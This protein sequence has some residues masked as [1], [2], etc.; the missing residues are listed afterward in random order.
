MNLFPIKIHL[1]QNPHPEICWVFFTVVC[2]ICQALGRTYNFL[3][4]V[5]IQ[6][7]RVVLHT[8]LLCVNVFY[9]Y[10]KI[11]RTSKLKWNT[12]ISDQKKNFWSN[13]W[14]SNHEK[15]V[16]IS[17]Y[18]T[19]KEK[20][21]KQNEKDPKPERAFHLVAPSIKIPFKYFAINY[22]CASFHIIHS[23]PILLLLWSEMSQDSAY[24]IHLK[25]SR[26]D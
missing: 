6:L 16:S 18:W 22:G 23:S 10:V 14:F 9:V 3:T 2:H 17:N 5:K 15:G 12:L 13:V 11:L 1:Y 19:E 25:C 21:K 20:K 26:I 8:I 7:W 24:S 4:V